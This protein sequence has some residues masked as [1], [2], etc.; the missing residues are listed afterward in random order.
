MSNFITLLPIVVFIFGMVGVGFYI[1]KKSEKDRSENYSKDYFIGGRSL[2]GFVLAM[3]LV[4]TYGSVSSFVGGP[5]LAWARGF[6]WLYYASIQIAAAYLVLGVLGKKMAVIARRI[7]AVTIP[8]LIR[9]RYQSNL[10]GT[11]AALVIVIFFSTQMVA[12]FIGGAKLFEAATGYSYLTGL[13]LFGVATIVYTSVGGFKAVAITDTVCAILMILG[14]MLIAGGLLRA[15]GGFEN[16]MQTIRT[17]APELL[18]PFAGG[19]VTPALLMS[20]WFLVGFGLVGLPQSAVRNMSFKSTQAVH[21]AMIYG[22]VALGVMMVGM[23]LLGVLSRAVITDTTITNTDSIMP[24]LVM[25]TLPP[26]LAGIAITGPLAASMSTISSL[27]IAASSALV[28]DIY[29]FHLEKKNRKVD[30]KKVSIISVAVTLV[31]GIIVFLFSIRPPDLIVWI[32]LFAFGGLQTAFLWALLLG[33]FWK[34]ANTTG[35]LLSM[36]GGTGLY[37]LLSAFNVSWFEMHNVVWGILFGLILF[38]AGSLATQPMDDRI[39]RLYF[40]ETY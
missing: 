5:G 28:R 18:D 25:Q 35:A 4:A 38:V 21:R 9:H 3:T 34:R 10:L 14:T 31:I 39:G 29:E 12:Q 15:G 7:D 37:I 11:I 20:G 36:V 32:N 13:V 33:M 23:H 27:L 22:T 16:V 17:D 2:G 8:D 1:Q 6:G 24:M 30:Q 26:I 40:P 19:L